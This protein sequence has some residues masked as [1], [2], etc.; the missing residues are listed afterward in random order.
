M[1]FFFEELQ[2]IT[3]WLVRL[4][5]ELKSILLS[6][7]K[8]PHMMSSL[9][10]TPLTKTKKLIGDAGIT[11]TNMFVTSPLCCPS[12]SSILTGQYVHNHLVWNNSLSGNCSSLFWQKTLEP[13]LFPVQLQKNGYKTFFAG[14]Y[15]N[16][17]GHK[18]V[19]GVEHVPPGW[20]T[21]NG[22]VGNSAYYNYTL[23]VNGVL[24]SHGDSYKADYLTDLISRR[25]AK[26]IQLQ[27]AKKKP[28]FM[29]LSTPAPHSPFTSAPQ[30]SKNF[31]DKKAPRDKSFNVKSKDKHWLVRNAASPMPNK[32]ISFIDDT[33]RN[34]WKTLLSVDDLVENV[35]KQL[36]ANGQLN[37]TYIFFTSDNG[38]HLGQFSLSFD[39]RQLYDFD[40]RV[41]LFVRGP[42]IKPKQQRKEFVLN[43]DFAPTFLNLTGIPSRY[44]TD[45]KSL[46]P[47]LQPNETKEVKFR[48]NCLIEHKGEAHVEIRQCPQYKNQ[49]LATC[50]S[51]CVCEDSWN[52]TYGC[53]RQLSP[54]ENFK[55]CEFEDQD[56][57]IEMYDLN[58]DPFELT[59]IASTADPK[60]VSQLS[61]KLATLSLCKGLSCQEATLL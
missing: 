55:Y 9:Y 8:S 33:F 59:N 41:P 57:F 17:Y 10:K 34:R 58:K 43:I 24:E 27:S 6:F 15:L 1:K 16:Q 48:Q 60:F 45:G 35:V 2:S 42:G 26:F 36:S 18:S 50:D 51:N 7:R 53:V 23:S 46:W 14:K 32:T 31:T 61:Q 11:F 25:A 39:K 13:T 47:L 49:G 21:W 44:S 30:Y 38:Y 5:M 37:N 12:R 20:T 28:F 52:N 22:L 56:H 29:M 3:E 4:L 40:N 54:N 19:G